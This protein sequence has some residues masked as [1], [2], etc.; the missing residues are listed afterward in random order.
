MDRPMRLL[1]NF[2]FAV[3]SKKLENAFGRRQF[4]LAERL[5]AI[6]L[7]THCGSGKYKSASTILQQLQQFFVMPSVSRSLSVLSDAPRRAAPCRRRHG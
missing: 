3:R 4:Y 1:I 7:Y 6:L 5:Q 2:S